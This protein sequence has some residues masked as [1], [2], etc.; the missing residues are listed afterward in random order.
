MAKIL[1]LGANGQVGTVLSEALRRR[2]GREEVLT[3][4]LNAPRQQSG[5]H[6]LLD[7]RDEAGLRKVIEEN[8]VRQ[9][10]HLA[11]ILSARGE[12]DP[13]QTWKIN[14]DG[15]L[16]V[17]ESAVACHLERVFYPS[18]MAV[19]G[20]TTPREMTPQEASFIPATVYGISK[21]SS[22][23]WC[24]Y[25][26]G[27][28]GLDVRSIRYPGIVGWQSP[29]GGGTTDYAVEIFHAALL[30]GKYT[31]FLKPDTRLPMMYMD[32]SI[33]A[34]L[35]LMDAPTEK[36]RHRTAYNLTAMS[37]TP[38]ELAAE[39]CRHLPG[40]HIEYKPD[41][42]QAIADSW[43]A[44]IDDGCAREEW[45]WRP[46]YDLAQMTADMI[47]QLNSNPDLLKG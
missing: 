42:R 26:A 38:E 1:V 8:G 34:T 36:I 5:P 23:L 12:K 16:N 24:N 31:C 4:D 40:F 2:W 39:I 45:G 6:L 44:S 19:F 20:P 29:P 3:S 21:Y 14:M 9:I 25:Y 11:A 35:E 22:E 47:K 10:Y 15:L 37:F 46:D 32:D 17:L 7:V 13:L 28:Y 41:F 18:S 43:T 27:R 33:R 30:H